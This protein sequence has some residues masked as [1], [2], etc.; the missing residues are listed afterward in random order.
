MIRLSVSTG[1]AVLF[2]MLFITLLMPAYAMAQDQPGAT[3]VPA[4]TTLGKVAEKT[5][6]S[7]FFLLA[8]ACIIGIGGVMIFRRYRR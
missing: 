4:P 6:P 1:Y 8:G 2:T 7:I 3:A 5:S